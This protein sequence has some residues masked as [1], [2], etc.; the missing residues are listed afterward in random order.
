MAA[1]D[2]H[3]KAFN[4]YLDGRSL[5]NLRTVAK[6]TDLSISAILRIIFS[7]PV[8]AS[9]FPKDIRSRILNRLETA[10]RGE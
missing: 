10:R 4:I 8:N 6:D 3:L 1:T 9:E 5:E 7:T 2:A